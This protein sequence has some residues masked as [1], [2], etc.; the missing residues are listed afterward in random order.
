M[1]LL[2]RLVLGSSVVALA[3]GL[4]GCSGQAAP[5]AAPTSAVPATTSPAPTPT[6]TP[7][8]TPTSVIELTAD[9][10]ARVM[11]SSAATSCTFTLDSTSQGQEITADGAV[12]TAADGTDELVLKMA[13]PGQSNAEFRV[14]GGVWYVNMGDQTGGKFITGDPSDPDGP[15][16]GMAGVFDSVNPN[17]GFAVFADAIVSVTPTGGSELVG[18]V[19]TQAYDIV[20]DTTKLTDKVRA[21][22]FDDTAPLP[23]QVSFRYWVAADGLVRRME[24][25]VQGEHQV[26]TFSNWGEPVDI[27]APAPDQIID[28]G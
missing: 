10:F 17:R 2:R 8:P 27:A 9:T 20:I 22:Q 11:S 18:G 5:E 6:P 15:F 14:V 7:S 26:M 1:A 13:V 28:L 24:G 16:A 12:R 3:A 23:M 4:V 19:P 25:D 21:E